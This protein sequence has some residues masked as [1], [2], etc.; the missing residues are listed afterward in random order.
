[1]RTTGPV[2]TRTPAACG[3]VCGAG[4]GVCAL[5]TPVHRHLRINTAEKRVDKPD[6]LS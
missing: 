5:A 4:V 2:D 3:P 1:M 6:S